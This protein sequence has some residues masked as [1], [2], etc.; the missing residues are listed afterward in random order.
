MAPP[1][2]QIVIWWGLQLDPLNLGPTVA[3]VVPVVVPVKF[4]AVMDDV[5]QDNGQ[6]LEEAMDN[7]NEWENKKEDQIPPGQLPSSVDDDNQDSD[8]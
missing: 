8:S 7:S 3:K 1:F 6:L 5:E 4:H 2:A